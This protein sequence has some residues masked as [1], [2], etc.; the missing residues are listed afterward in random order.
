M[1]PPKFILELAA[2]IALSLDYMGAYIMAVL[3]K[4]PIEGMTLFVYILI[5]LIVSFLFGIYFVDLRK[6]VIYTAVSIVIGMFLA[7]ALM[8]APPMILASEYMSIDAAI[9]MAVTLISKL[10]LVGVTFAFV[11]TIAGCIVADML[12]ESID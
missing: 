3:W 7:I 1:H 2:T 12:A 8:S 10:L 6:S 4:W 5:V 11:G 9:S